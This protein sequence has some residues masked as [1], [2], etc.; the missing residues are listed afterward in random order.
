M[1]SRSKTRR[2]KE[3]HAWGIERSINVE[4]QVKGGDL[5]N[6]QDISTK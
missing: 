5:N 3:S 4:I 1:V 6:G 2:E